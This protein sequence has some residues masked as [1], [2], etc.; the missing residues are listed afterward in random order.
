[1]SCNARK[2]TFRSSAGTKGRGVPV[3]FSQNSELEEKDRSTDVNFS[4]VVNVISSCSSL[5]PACAAARVSALAGGDE[6]TASTLESASATSFYVAEIC[7][8][9]RYKGQMTDFTCQIA[10]RVAT[11]A[12]CQR[13]VVGHDVE[14][15]SL[16]EIP[17]VFDG[18]VGSKELATEGAVGSLSRF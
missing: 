10:I 8:E 9:L 16:K 13:L 18:E 5:S 2:T 11:E 15:A 17:A 12:I 1:M 7:R 3:E 4:E 6:K 14:S